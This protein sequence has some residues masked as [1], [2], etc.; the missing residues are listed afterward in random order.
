MVCRSAADFGHERQRALGAEQH[1]GIGDHLAH[2]VRHGLEAVV[3]DA[4][5][6]DVGEARSQE[7]G[8][9]ESGMQSKMSHAHVQYIKS[10]AACAQPQATS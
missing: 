2:V 7:S 1:V 6:V 4:N 9:Q 10:A 8:C 5:D 3:A